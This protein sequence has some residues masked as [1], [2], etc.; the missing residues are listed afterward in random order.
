MQKHTEIAEQDL[1]CEIRRSAPRFTASPWISLGVSLLVSAITALT[2]TMFFH[3]KDRIYLLYYF[4]PILF[5]AI[6]WFFERVSRGSRLKVSQW[7]IDGVVVAVSV[8]RSFLPIPLISGHALFLTYSL[9]TTDTWI[10]RVTAALILSEI[11]YIKL[12][13]WHDW[14]FYGGVIAGSLIGLVF[15]WTKSHS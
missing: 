1:N 14:T 2:I 3:G 12:F 7:T 9:F 13:L 6:T 10:P 11:C 15:R 8:A 4:V 5:P